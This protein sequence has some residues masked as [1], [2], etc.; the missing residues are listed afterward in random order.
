MKTDEKKLGS[1]LQEL[2][3]YCE[4]PLGAFYIKNCF[5]EAALLMQ[6]QDPRIKSE[7][8]RFYAYRIVAFYKGKLVLDSR[9]QPAVDSEILQHKNLIPFLKDNILKTAQ[10][11]T[12]QFENLLV[13]M[14]KDWSGIS[15]IITTY[16]GRLYKAARCI[17]KFD[18]R[19]LEQN[20]QR[21]LSKTGI[22]GRRK[23]S[24]GALP[25]IGMLAILLFSFLESSESYNYGTPGNLAI[26]LLLTLLCAYK[27]EST[28][29][30]AFNNQL[31]KALALQISEPISE[32][33]LHP[34][35]KPAVPIKK[36]LKREEKEERVEEV[37]LKE[38][39]FRVRV[40]LTPEAMNEL[41][42]EEESKPRQPKVKTR[43]S[44]MANR[45]LVPS[46][47][48]AHDIPFFPNNFGQPFANLAKGDLIELSRGRGGIHAIFYK[49]VFENDTGITAD[50][51][52]S[53]ENEFKKAKFARSKGENG[54]KLLSSNRGE[55]LYEIKI[56][57]DD[58]LLG[59]ECEILPQKKVIV[60]C[61]YCKKGLHDKSTH[62]FEIVTHRI[63]QLKAQQ[64]EYDSNN[65][66]I[67]LSF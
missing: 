23:V 3:T 59:K 37:V 42:T 15:R 49:D 43:K 11:E 39:N 55:K 66:A 63:N 67:E 4:T 26:T 57:S 24:G 13:K 9:Y 14:E 8:A 1:E 62:P 22:V 61:Y 20:R 36:G 47:S 10:K 19:I 34:V 2:K 60:F 28:T 18:K 45:F 64:K 12:Q 31:N 6:N 33:A 32:R 29:F 17:K 30:G 25:L 52:Q 38:S 35:S 54:I 58:R 51:I 48:K 44:T 7:V 16:E 40:T 46:T 5:F 56:R 41:R 27:C 65:P 21:L 53:F 50:S